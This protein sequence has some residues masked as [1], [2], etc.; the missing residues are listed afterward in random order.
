EHAGVMLFC[1]RMTRGPGRDGRDLGLVDYQ[2][3]PRF[4]YG[5]VSGLVSVMAGA[6]PVSILKET[7]ELFAFEFV[8]GDDRIVSAFSLKDK[9]QL[10]FESDA[11]GVTSFDSMGNRGHVFEGGSAQLQLDGYPRY[12]VFESATT[13]KLSD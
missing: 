9:G 12:L 3:C 1:G 7:G 4:S 10:M 6:S 11:S 8:R 13:I 2:Y 5:A